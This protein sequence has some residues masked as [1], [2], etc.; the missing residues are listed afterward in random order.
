VP[1][2]LVQV[3]WA[4]GRVV[5]PVEVLVAM[6]VGMLVVVVMAVAMV[7]SLFL[8]T[9]PIYG[10]ML[11]TYLILGGCGGGCGGCGG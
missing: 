5:D 7:V 11:L 9:L 4:L 6:R 2:A 3:L 1:Q 8:I 10:N